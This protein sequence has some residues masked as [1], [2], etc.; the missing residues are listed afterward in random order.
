M[1]SRQ[2]HLVIPTTGRPSCAE[3]VRQALLREP[4]LARLTIVSQGPHPVMG[5]DVV[6][7]ATNG[8]SVSEVSLP[9]PV[10]AA[11]ARDL[12]ARIGQEEFVGFLDDDIFFEQGSLSEL[13]DHCRDNDL[14]GACGVVTNAAE[15]TAVYRVM[16]RLLFRRIFAD[17]RSRGP[18]SKMPFNSRVLNGGVT[19]Y[20]RECYLRCAHTQER[21][22]GYTWG[23]D[24]ELSFCVSQHRRLAVV[25]TVRV[26]NEASGYRASGPTP[27]HVAL[28]RLERYRSFAERHA[29]S[30]LDWVAYAG[31]TVGVLAAG[32]RQ[33]GGLSILRAATR[34]LARAFWRA[35]SPS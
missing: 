7:V 15:N 11:W 22:S 1:G 16:K 28:R 24:F 27:R 26:R 21:F 4:E 30:R 19:V 29:T 3:V 9:Q 14:G 31:V 35:L 32:L 6:E 34:E 8:I 23:E 13:V 12:G 33:G 5:E 20:R 2:L 25:P 17:P 10:G 18:G